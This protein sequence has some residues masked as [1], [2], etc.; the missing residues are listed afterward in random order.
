MHEQGGFHQ[1][2]GA[3][4]VARVELHELRQAV[5]GAVDAA[6]DGADIGAA[7]LG[8]LLVGQP[9]GGDQQKRLALIQGSLLRALSMSAKSRRAPWLG[10]TATFRPMRLPGLR[11]RACACGPGSGNRCAG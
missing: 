3:E 4:I 6:F 5:A 11:P 1:T 8:G 2:V 9:L 10:I 7:D